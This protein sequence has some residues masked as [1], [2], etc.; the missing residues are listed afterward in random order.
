MFAVRLFWAAV[1]GFLAG[2][3]LRS[4]MPLGAASAAFVCVLA[5]ALAILPLLGFFRR[6]HA[7]IAVVALCALALGSA[8]M[9]YGVFAPDTALAARAGS[10]VS[11]AGIVAEEPDVRESQVRIVVAVE[12]FA[13]STHA[14]DARVLA[15]LPAFT[16]VTYG[17]RITVRGVLEAPSAFDTDGGRLFDYPGYLAARGILFEL[18][19]AQIVSC[20]AGAYGFFSY[21]YGAKR[22]YL[23]GTQAVLPEPQAGL[24]GG[25]VAGDKRSVGTEVADE[26]KRT[27]LTH[28]LVLSG[29]NIAVVAVAAAWVFG[30]F[31]FGRVS[32]TALSIAA[33]ILFVLATGA[34][35]NAVRAAGMAFVAAYARIAGREFAALRALAL[36][37]AG[38][39]A[40]NP[41]LLAFDPGFQ[42]SAVATFGLVAF[43][44]AIARWAAWVPE[45]FGVRE[46][47]AATVSTQLTVLP[48][49]L[50]QSGSLSLVALPA[51]LLALV[52]IPPAMLAS[53]VAALGGI[54]AGPLAVP[55]AAPAYILLS[56]V[57]GVAHVFALL[58]FS[59]VTVPAFSIWF[60]LPAYA[61]ALLAA[62]RAY[63]KPAAEEPRPVE[64]PIE[65]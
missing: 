34:S 54:V 3:F 55:L 22:A 56:Y 48:L 12:R 36:V 35:A 50:W 29:Y 18:S 60:L 30:R 62:Q 27:S 49:L 13:S 40:W 58:P 53:F 2:V 9:H 16:E 57:I 5:G 24:A 21:L 11:L 63:A 51:N 38:M 45:S 31:R 28:I 19:R 7:L 44:G 20:E 42:L 15:V 1:M 39:V 33:V 8:R 59:A 47:F 61:L 65:R 26:F 46:L 41:Y 6:T 52:A 37:C 32:R 10:D 25:I 64:A 43:S 17:D 4:S 23:E 14:V